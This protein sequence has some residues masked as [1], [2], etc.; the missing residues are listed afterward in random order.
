VKILF[1][2][3]NCKGYLGLGGGVSPINVDFN[4][5]SYDSTGTNIIAT[6]AAS[7]G[8]YNT[9][10][11]NGQAL[12]GVDFNLGNGICFG[13][14]VGYRYLNA[15]DFKK[16]SNTLAV[17]TKNGA[18]G[19]PGSPDSATTNMPINDPTTALTLDFSGIEGG[20]NLTFSF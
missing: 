20:L 14:Y 8:T 2:D 19:L 7:S 5:I 16:G 3:K 4:K 6:D 13:P 9:M 17:D 11:I 12:L 1:G 10:A 15:T 18:V